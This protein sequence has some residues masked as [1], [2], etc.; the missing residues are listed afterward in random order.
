MLSAE[1]A[2][3]TSIAK[4]FDCLEFNVR[5]YGHKLLIKPS[6]RSVKSFLE[7]IKIEIRKFIR[8]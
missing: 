7:S 2:L 8:Y 6:K 4:G 5:K 1:K 3:I